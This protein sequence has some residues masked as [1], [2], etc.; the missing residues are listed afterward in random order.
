M[1]KKQEL[2]STQV[3]KPQYYSWGS[4]NVGEALPDAAKS[5]V[6]EL[7]PS[8]D[9]YLG[10][11]V[12]AD[13]KV[14]VAYVCFKTEENGPEYCLKGTTDGSA[15]DAN[16]TVLEEAFGASA[17]SFGDAYS[18]CGADGLGAYADSDGFVG[19]DV[20][21]AYCY[22]RSDGSLECVEW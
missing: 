17:C 8:Y 20:D 12:D 21:R 16:K 19:A 2:P 13:N 4:G 11:D 15:Y 9:F 10:L 22:V 5:T 1:E 7:N 18:H 6:E 3:Y 14:S